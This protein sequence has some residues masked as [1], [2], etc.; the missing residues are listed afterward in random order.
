MVQ[1]S[2]DAEGFH[3]LGR[4]EREL[5]RVWVWVWGERSGGE[6]MCV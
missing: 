2:F 3:M 1:L 4:R 5:G 6:G